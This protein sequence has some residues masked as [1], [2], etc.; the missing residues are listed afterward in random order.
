[1]YQ[2]SGLIIAMFLFGCV[3]INKYTHPDEIL[4][5]PDIQ[6]E[7]RFTKGIPICPYCKKPTER[8]GGMGEVTMMYFPPV[9]DKEGNNT[10]PDRNIKTTY[11]RCQECGK[12]YTIIGNAVD[13][14][15]Y[16]LD[17]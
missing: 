8:S 13:G 6:E 12:D 7:V 5:T 3:S 1:M 14:Y 4:N 2:Y 11:W 16:I 9:W 17:K 10:N 15:R